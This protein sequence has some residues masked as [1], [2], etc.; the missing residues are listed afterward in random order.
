MNREV[1]RLGMNVPDPVESRRAGAG[2]IVRFVYAALVFGILGF[3]VIRFGAP[4]VLLNGPGVVT[5]QRSVISSPYVVRVERMD[6]RPGTKVEAGTLIAMVSSPQVNQTASDL[7]LAL[8]EITGSEAELRVKARVARDS[9]DAAR[10]R[11]RMADDT[12]QRLEKANSAED[13]G[14][15]YRAD[16]Y[17]ERAVAVQSLL[18]LEAEAEE[19]AAQ[20]VRLEA[21]RREIRGQFDAVKSEFDGGRILSPARGIIAPRT[22][23]AGETMLAGSSIAEIF[24]DGDTFVDWY[25]PNFRLVDPRPGQRVIV[26]YG[27]TRLPGTISEILPISD[28]LESRRSSILR[29]PSAGQIGRIRFDPGVLPP[30]LNATVHVHMFYSEFTDHIAWA[31]VRLFNFN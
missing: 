23:Y 6:V 13:F 14:L 15:I 28:Q 21:V 30:T 4:L 22:S 16:V 12:L 11:F 18:A 10:S 24:L 8:A 5:A 2:R 1:H 29:E 19:A 31:L 20:L 27:R 7:L 17:R 3:F 25:I 9:I 26:V